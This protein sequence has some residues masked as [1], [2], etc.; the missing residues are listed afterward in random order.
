MLRQFYKYVYDSFVAFS[1]VAGSMETYRDAVHM[2]T[3]PYP[4]HVTYQ[5]CMLLSRR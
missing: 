2:G 1:K 3:I 4:Y 5:S